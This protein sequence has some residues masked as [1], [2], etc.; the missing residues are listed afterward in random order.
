[1]NDNNFIGFYQAEEVLCDDI[2]DFY[3]QHKKYAIKGLSAKSTDEINEDVNVK[4][5]N[6]LLISAQHLYYP[7]DEY[8]KHL[9]E[10]LDKYIKIYIDANNY[11][12][13][14]IVEDYNIQH[15]P[16]GGGFKTWHFESASLASIRRILVFMTYLND[17]PDGGTMFKYQNITTPAKKGSTVIWPAGFTHTHKGQIS[18]T[19]EKFIVTGWWSLID[20]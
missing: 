19:K 17:V 12:R 11:S 2:I 4:D 13:F 3:N 5:S 10:S 14:K 8:R 16:I 1:M 6:D 9:Q 20:E 18:H 7:M 15:Y